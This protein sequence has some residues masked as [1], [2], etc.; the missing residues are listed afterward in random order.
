MESYQSLS[1]RFKVIEP[2]ISPSRTQCQ[3]PKN[4]IIRYMIAHKVIDMFIVPNVATIFLGSFIWFSNGKITPI[5][6]KEY[7]AV[8]NQIGIPLLK[9]FRKVYSNLKQLVTFFTYTICSHIIRIRYIII[10]TFQMLELQKWAEDLKMHNS[11][12]WS[13]HKVTWE[14]M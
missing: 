11:I 5:P 10:T 3:H 4:P 12:W 14:L 9:H 1:G 13:A 7:I 6:S 2:Y 8:A